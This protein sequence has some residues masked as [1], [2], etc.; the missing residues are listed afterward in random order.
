MRSESE[1]LLD[2]ADRQQQP[3]STPELTDDDNNYFVEGNIGGMQGT[4][5]LPVDKDRR[6]DKPSR[7]L[8][9]EGIFEENGK[10]KGLSRPL[11]RT[12]TEREVGE[13]SLTRL[14]RVLGLLETKSTTQETNSANN[15][16]GP[17]RPLSRVRDTAL[18]KY[19][20]ELEQG[21]N[22]EPKSLDRLIEALEKDQR[23]AYKE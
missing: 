17:S 10:N 11:N 14:D 3:T 19:F 12:H 5:S 8:D 1:T 2:H 18:G 21:R 20:E 9:I 15:G 7:I 13:D 16:N 4:I 23:K 6:H 22:E